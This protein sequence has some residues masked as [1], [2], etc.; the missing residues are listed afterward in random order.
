[1]I[2]IAPSILSA[3]FA[4]LEDAVKESEA[5]GAER[6]HIDVMDGHF[7]PNISMGPVVVEALRPNTNLLIETHLMIENPDRY[8]GDFV[9][10]GADIVIVHQENV[11]HLH[12]VIQQIKEHGKQAGVALNPGTPVHMLDC[13]FADLDMVLAMTVNPGFSGQKFISSV[14]PK[15][16][17]I[18]DRIDAGNSECDLEVDGGVNETTGPQAV[19]AGANVLVAATAIFKHP[20]GISACIQTLRH[21]SDPQTARV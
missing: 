3:D 16:R 11:P 6:V 5:A 20:D 19:D 14:L 1:M 2:H 13:V 7:V 4:N 21:R 12:R 15:V 17:E 18:R 9:K 8:I 10:A